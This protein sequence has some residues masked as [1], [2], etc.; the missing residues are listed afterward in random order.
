[1]LKCQK[2]SQPAGGYPPQPPP[3]TLPPCLNTL[4]VDTYVR[5]K[6]SSS[7][8]TRPRNEIASKANRKNRGARGKF[9]FTRAALRCIQ[10]D[11]ARVKATKSEFSPASRFNRYYD[12][13]R[14]CSH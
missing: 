3:V 9:A 2:F 5:K 11:A 8:L 13:K 7:G 4:G 10:T 12:L 6:Q 1:M 14:D